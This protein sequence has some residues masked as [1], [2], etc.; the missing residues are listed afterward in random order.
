MVDLESLRASIMLSLGTLAN[1]V[2]PSLL[3]LIPLLLGIWATVNLAVSPL[4]VGTKR[5]LSSTLISILC[6]VLPN[7]ILRK[8]TPS[9][10][11]AIRSGSTSRVVALKV[12]VCIV[13]EIFASFC[14]GSDQAFE[15]FDH[16]LPGFLALISL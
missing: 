9:S 5:I 4:A 15:F 8:K 12:A 7:G 6:S 13:L 14:S 16:C 1:I 11:L 10:P 3:M 2:I